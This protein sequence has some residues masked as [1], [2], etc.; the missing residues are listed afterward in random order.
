MSYWPHCLHKLNEQLCKQGDTV[1]NNSQ[2]L[3]HL[4]TMIKFKDLVVYVTVNYNAGRAIYHGSS[5]LVL[6]L[7]MCSGTIHSIFHI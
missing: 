5:P 3:L 2:N 6:F 7:H 4:V 1:K